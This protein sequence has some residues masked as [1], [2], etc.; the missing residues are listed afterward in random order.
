[1]NG[2]IVGSG[3]EAMA[4]LQKS[5]RSLAS[6]ISESAIKANEY[7]VSSTA[8]A[9]GQWRLCYVPGSKTT[10]VVGTEANASAIG[11]ELQSY[12]NRTDTIM[13]GIN[14]LD[15][16]MFFTANIYPGLTAGG[17]NGPQLH[18]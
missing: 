18:L 10:G 14:T 8:Y 5:F 2:Y 9:S 13:S 16:Q 3:S 17:T 4:E 6:I 15:T 7:N 1:M 12:S 11:L